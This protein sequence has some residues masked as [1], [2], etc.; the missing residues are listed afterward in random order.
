MKV[1]DEIEEE[2]QILRDNVYDSITDKFTFDTKAH[3]LSPKYFTIVAKTVSKLIEFAK[4]AK[5]L[6]IDLISNDENLLTAV[7]GIGWKVDKGL[8]AIKDLQ[9]RVSALE[10]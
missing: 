9:Q 1:S 6:G 5:T 3:L 8:L 4:N 10:K 2:E 7:S